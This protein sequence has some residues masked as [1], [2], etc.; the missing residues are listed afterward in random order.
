MRHGQ[1]SI[2]RFLLATAAAALLGSCSEI[3]RPTPEPFYAVPVPPAKQEFRWSNGKLPKSFD[4]ARAAAAPETD[5]VRAIFEGLTETDARTLQAVPAAADKWSS[6]DEFHTWTFHIRKD[7]RWSNGERVTAQDFVR[8]WKRLASLGEKAAHPEL[9]QNIVGLGTPQHASPPASGDLLD[10]VPLG[11]AALRQVRTEQANTAPKTQ[12]TAALPNSSSAEKN[13]GKAPAAKPVRPKTGIDAVDD[14][15]LKVTL[16]AGDKDFP[17]L[18]A[19]AAFRPVYLDGAEFESDPLDPGVVTNGAFKVTGV[20]RDGVVL[21]RSQTYWNASAVSLDVVRFVPIES[22][23]AALDAY[24]RG[25]VDAVTNADFGPT[26]LK[27]LAPYDDFRQTTHSAVALYEFNSKNPP[28]DDRRVR[29]A[30]AI[31]IDRERLTGGDL[32]GSAQPAT[33]FLPLGDQLNEPIALDVDRAKQL[34]ESAGF[35]NGEGFPKIRLVIN[36][37]DIQQRIARSVARMWRQNLNLETDI[38][39][40]ETAEL[41]AERSSGQFDLI[42]RGVV[43]P[44]ADQ[45]VSLAA[46]FEPISKTATQNPALRAEPD[47]PERPLLPASGPN[48]GIGDSEAPEQEDMIVAEPGDQWSA[49]EAAMLDFNAIPLYFPMSYSLVKPYVKGF[50]TN[51]LD[52]P[53]LREISIDNSWQ[54]RQGR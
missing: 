36:R 44:S 23:E 9:F 40:K 20:G 50:E 52:A 35:A 18:V 43:L 28:F 41:D 29:E 14:Q 7:A 13:D 16:F 17:R 21:G 47:R 30:L 11:T 33:S 38:I 51:P 22:A 12:P 4:P 8:S 3:Q 34:L 32:E 49:N 2:Y 5:V 39:V 42:R 24:R 54:P 48:A 26:V 10:T 1:R 15:T 6:S 31:T 53:V 46:I 25:D 19:N 27:L 37:N 45:A